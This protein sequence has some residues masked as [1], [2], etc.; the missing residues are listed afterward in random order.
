MSATG[1]VRLDADPDAGFDI[2]TTVRKDRTVDLTAF[3]VLGKGGSYRLYGVDMLTA[4]ADDE[5]AFKFPVT[6]IAI[7]LNRGDPT[8][9]MTKAGPASDDRHRKRTRPLCK[10]S[11]ACS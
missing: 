9:G 8:V 5:G 4:L 2:Y 1:K 6:D 10:P 7:G 11:S 3:A